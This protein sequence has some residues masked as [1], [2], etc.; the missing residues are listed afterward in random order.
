MPPIMV[1][2]VGW[3]LAVGSQP[4]KVGTMGQGIQDGVASLPLPTRQALGRAWAILDALV[5]YV[6]T[7]VLWCHV[8]L[9]YDM[10][11]WW[12]VVS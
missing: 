5:Q 4:P 9:C 10:A 11:Q 12:R 1:V 2:H 7:A 8:I 6:F 3:Q